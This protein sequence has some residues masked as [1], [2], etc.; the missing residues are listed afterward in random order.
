MDE[1]GRGTTVRDG[2]AIAFSTIM[3][4]HRVNRSRTLFATHFHELADMLG[5]TETQTSGDLAN[6]FEGIDFFCTDVQETSVRLDLLLWPET[7]IKQLAGRSLLI[8]ASTTLRRQQRQPWHQGCPASEHAARCDCYGG[9][10][11]CRIQDWRHNHG[12]VFASRAWIT[13]C[14][15]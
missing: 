3:H 13:D 15:W 14:H 4:L 7:L 9:R 6:T 11:A 5:Y 10:G 2:L 12:Q 8:F 1:V